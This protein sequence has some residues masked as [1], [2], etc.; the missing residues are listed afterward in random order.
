MAKH[1]VVYPDGAPK[2]EDLLN[3]I[4]LE[5][6][7]R[8]WKSLGLDDEESLAA[9]QI[10]IMC[11]PKGGDSIRG[12][13]GLRKLRYSPADWGVGKRGALRVCYVYFEKYG[14]VLLVHV[15][16]KSKTDNM[17]AASRQA[18]RKVIGRIEAA[19]REQHGF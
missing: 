5:P 14:C 8:A 17:S 7:S 19:L 3:F 11:S 18:V 15:Y 2:P 9:L 6:F 10:A 4:E 13:N 16:R 1:T 12:T